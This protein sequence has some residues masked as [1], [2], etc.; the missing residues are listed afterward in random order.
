MKISLCCLNIVRTLL[1]ANF[2]RRDLSVDAT[3]KQTENYVVR[4]EKPFFLTCIGTASFLFFALVIYGVNSEESQRASVY[5]FSETHQEELLQYRYEP[6]IIMSGRNYTDVAN[7]DA[8]QLSN[9][10]VVSWFQSEM[11]RLPGNRSNAYIVNKGGVGGDELGR[12]MN[13]GIWMNQLGKIRAG[14][15]SMNATDMYVTSPRKYNDGKWHFVALTYDGL[16]LV[17]YIDGVVVARSSHKGIVLP[18][19]TG[20][21]PV[22]IG[23]NSLIAQ[24]YFV[25]KVD[26]VRIWNRAL[27]SGDVLK[28]FKTGTFDTKGQVLYVPDPVQLNSYSK[29]KMPNLRDPGLKAEIVIDGLDTAVRMAFLG[30]NDIIVSEQ[31]KNTLKRIVKDQIFEIPLPNLGNNQKPTCICGIAVTNGQNDSV[32]IFLSYYMSQDSVSEKS[33]N[34]LYRY[35]LLD[36]E[37]INPHLL[38][39]IPGEPGP[40]H[41]GGT[42]VVGPDNSIFLAGG[43]HDRNDTEAEN[44]KNASEPDGSAGIIR[45]TQSGQVVEGILGS[46]DPLNKYYAYG[47]RNSFGMDFDPI[48][49]K[50]WNTDNGLDSNDEINLVEPGFNSG[51]KQIMGMS[52]RIEGFDSRSLVDF[53]GKG[54]YSDP[55]F[56]WL[57]PVGPTALIFLTSNKLGSNYTNDLFAADVNNGNIY[58]FDL[59]ENR[60][61]LYLKGV[62]EDKIA[63]TMEELQP[64]L[65][66]EG[67]GGITDMQVGPYDGYLY[68]V[69]IGEGKI[70][71][72]R[73]AN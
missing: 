11:N 37:L 67:F 17:L 61:E 19:N 41:N 52:N 34:Y 6:Y 31:H 7:T 51:W 1:L 9:F 28:S 73:N 2:I 49:G 71:R 27:A 47:I 63:N 18:D 70:F 45:I 29:N 58:H 48:T 5:A 25:G 12:N 40:R 72:I 23:A 54:K 44:L 14:F 39:F 8:L 10:T 57:D 59:N 42:V 35:T 13:Y 20:S 24:G 15:E 43:E 26:E 53:E 22:R 36:N 66:G 60:T 32:N 4:S 55:E 38:L 46:R 33:G 65:F 50:L 3:F 69:S 62:L 16:N 56:E 64:V 68:I 21:Q 30:Q